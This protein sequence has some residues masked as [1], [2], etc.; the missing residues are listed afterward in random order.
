MNRCPWLPPGLE[1][2]Q[3]Y[4]DEEWGVPSQDERHLFEMICLEGA[5]AGLSWWTILQKRE[6]YRKVFHQFDP[7]KVAEMTDRQLEKLV[8]DP[9]IVRHRG[10]IFGVRKNAESWLD[11][12]SR[13]GDV[14]EWLW[15][16]VGGKPTVNRWKKMEDYPA[17]TPESEALSKALKKEGFTFFG[18]TIAYAFMQAVG[19]VDDHA[20]DCFRSRK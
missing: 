8:A 10:K 14:A 18:P 7:V 16:L 17:K 6:H 20:E 4:H 13:E 1:L 9:G 2:Y 12:K 19:M 15:K 3:T 11:L 5:Q